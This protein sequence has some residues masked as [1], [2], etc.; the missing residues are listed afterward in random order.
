MNRTRRS[1][2]GAWIAAAIVCGWAAPAAAQVSNA[3]LAESLFREGKRLSGEHKFAEACPKFAESYKLDPGLGTL[4]NL[5]S[6]H[7]A[8]GK[9]ASAWAEFSEATSR[10]KREG[11][12][13]RAQ[14]ADEHMR[15]LEPKL[16][17][18]TISVAPGASIPG[19]V[20][21]FD[22]RE[23]SSAALGVKIPVD[24]GKHQIAAAAPGKL[25][26]SQTVDAPAAGGTLAVTLPALQDAPGAALAAPPVA[27]NPAAAPAATAAAATAEP[28]A[29]GTK[30]H[31]GLIVSG[32]AT[33]VFVIGAVASGIVYSGDRS[34][35]NTAN[36]NHDPT[37]F[38]KRDKRPRS[39]RS[40]WYSPAAPSCP[41]AS[42]S[43]F[44]PPAARTRP[45]PRPA[46]S[47]GCFRFSLPTAAVSRCKVHCEKFPL[48]F[49]RV[50][51]RG[52]RVHAAATP[53]QRH[54]GFDRRRDQ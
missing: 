4:L 35:F 52:S 40:I 19:L 49:A 25:S 15:A 6:C 36:A 47:Y 43:T 30:S 46:R 3:A 17:Y 12:N 26:N 22:S 33:G 1:S 23:L 38:D 16:A 51:G 5:A 29:P 20:I 18:F 48:A 31:T 8:E 34:S 44:W 50:V 39:V 28:P 7:E 10:A 53:G 41:R 24:P 9:P 13:E 32:V 11:D 21:T 14:L 45:R 27:A 37:R 54:A 42:W 2:G